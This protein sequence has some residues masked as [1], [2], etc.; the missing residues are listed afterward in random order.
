MRLARFARGSWGANK[1]GRLFR[2][3]SNSAAGTPPGLRNLTDDQKQLW[4]R[5]EAVQKDRVRNFC[6]IAHVDHGKST[7]ADRLIETCS[8]V[9]VVHAQVLDKLIVE[10]ERGITVKAQT[11]SL[12]Y[13]LEGNDYLINLV[14]TPGHSDFAFE[15]ERS[16]KACE[17]ALLVVDAAQGVQAQTFA[18]LAT[19]RKFKA[20]EQALFGENK[21]EFKFLPVINKID[22]Q[23]ADPDAVELQIAYTLGID[24][25]PVRVS[26]K[27]GIGIK[28]LLERIVTEIPSPSNFNWGF[29]A[30]LE[31]HFRSFVFD[32][33]FETN[34]GVYLMTRVFNGEVY[35][36]LPVALSTQVD[37]IYEV[38]EVGILI[39]ER[40]PLPKLTEGQ[41]GYVLIGIKDPKLSVQNLGCTIL[42]KSDHI[43]IKVPTEKEIEASSIDL[44]KSS[45]EKAS[46]THGAIYSIPSF[47]K[48]KQL[49]FCC[50]YPDDPEEFQQLDA[51]IHKLILEDPG[52][53]LTVESSPALGTGYRCGF[54]GVFH[55]E[56]FR[57]RLFTEY[58]LKTISTFP[59]VVYRAVLS[60]GSKQDVH[61]VLEA[62]TNCTWEEPWVLAQ[63]M[64]RREYEAVIKSLAEPRRGV[65]KHT[66]EMEDGQI[67][68][69]FEFPMSEVI[70]MF[71][72]EI[73]SSTH[74]FGSL[75]YT[76][77]EYR[78]ANIL[79]MVIA[80]TDEEVDAMSFLVHK[81]RAYDLGKKLCENLRKFIPQQLFDYNI[82]AKVGS[83]VIASEKVKGR[84][85]NVIA[86]CYGGD[87]SRKRK[88]IEN[89]KE[90]KKKMRM[91]GKVSMPSGAINNVFKNIQQ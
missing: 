58:N 76:L 29:T 17:G 83:R 66:K 6:I 78:P 45:S 10:R 39:P 85:K 73:K 69:E 5:L 62:P 28:T 40:T 26:A 9:Q 37:K 74:G 47:Q 88:L 30:G 13:N 15:V 1:D 89:Q 61:N 43:A 80:I 90:G 79:R 67:L 23:S 14:D 11:S 57:E 25:S 70:T 86:K 63:I 55:M 51:A 42:Q 3:F 34:K 68:L 22:L 4:K 38:K 36:G 48:A 49:V 46:S 53:S 31:S 18:H 65:F 52:V 19:A 7:L 75:D 12:I 16:L 2:E 77:H 87:Y 56:I 64:C 27:A 91:F 54:L 71:L 33:W 50:L 59:T 35:A 8:D 72:D 21:K 41:V 60:D 32:S 20:R 82:Q 44:G 81:S 84:S 24:T